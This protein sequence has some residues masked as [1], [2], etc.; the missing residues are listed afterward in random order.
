[1]IAL[2]TARSARHL[3]DDLSALTAALMR[4]DLEHRIEA[5][6]DASA[7]GELRARGGPLDL[8][9]SNEVS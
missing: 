8:G 2:V 9:L 3:D 5:W 7:V 1:V 4:V 6:D